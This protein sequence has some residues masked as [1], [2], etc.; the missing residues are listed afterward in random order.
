[1]SRIRRNLLQ[2]RPAQGK[3]FFGDGRAI[4]KGLQGLAADPL[5]GP[6]R[7]NANGLLP[8]ASRLSDWMLASLSSRGMGTLPQAREADAP[9]PGLQQTAPVLPG[10]FRKLPDAAQDNPFVAAARRYL[11]GTGK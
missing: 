8:Q 9:P 3:G 10:R 4:A 1:M 7:R 11:S 2:R 5:R 6:R